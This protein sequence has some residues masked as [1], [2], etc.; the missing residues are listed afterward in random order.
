MSSDL[1][2]LLILQKAL[3]VSFEA[4]I[5]DDYKIC[6]VLNGSSSR[7]KSYLRHK[8]RVDR[9]YSIWNVCLIS[10]KLSYHQ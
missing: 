3:Q 1:L 7:A 9:L 8:R 5:S 4:D 6:F 10:T 2:L